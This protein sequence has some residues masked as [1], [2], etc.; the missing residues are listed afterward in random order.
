MQYKLL[1]TTALAAAGLWAS[2]EAASA[3]AKVAP[4]SVVVGGYMEQTIGFGGN[5]HG[6]T[7]AFHGATVT[8]INR[9][10]Q[11][12]DS[13]IWF[14]GRTTLANGITVGFDI[15][16][17]G[18]TA[19]DQI[20]E[21]YLFVDGA[22]GRLVL[23]S[24]NAVDYI[25]HYGAPGAG[26]SYGPQES[27]ATTWIIRPTAV[28]IL[29]TTHTGKASGGGGTA[30]PATGNDQQRIS[31]YTPRFWGFQGG[32]SY[33]PNVNLE[34]SNGFADRNLNRANAFHG[35]VNFVNNFSGVQVNASAGIS[36][37]PKIN[38][39][40]AGTVGDEKVVDWS[41]GGQLG[42]MGFLVGAGFRSMD[43]NNRATEDG[44]AWGVGV[45]YTTG[46]FAIG[47]SYLGSKTE[48]LTTAGNAGK[49]KFNQILLSGAYTMGPGVDLIGAIFHVS[50]KDEASAT[51]NKNS[52]V[53][54]ITGLRLTF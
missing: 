42:Y 49:D 3:Q 34:D 22:F 46:P 25:M 9:I 26:R 10:S 7:Y 12:S 5:K 35:A 38:G 28:T 37:Y 52:G 41:V 8:K 47:V 18:N 45:S 39:S 54:A 15:Q 14:G 44:Y 17:E 24:E 1:A 23:G 20:D 16:L 48:G 27:A 11:Q 29:D 6:R 40:A 13:E 2:M 4:I 53:G 51:I 30:F 31:Y 43:V 19:G 50:Y 32:V 21:S 33:T 36:Y